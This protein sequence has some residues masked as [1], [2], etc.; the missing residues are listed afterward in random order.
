MIKRI[1]KEELLY[2]VND[3]GKIKLGTNLHRPNIG[4]TKYGAKIYWSIESL[5][6]A[7]ELAQDDGVDL[8]M[9]D[10]CLVS[11]E[12]SYYCKINGMRYKVTQKK[13]AMYGKIYHKIELI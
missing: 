10:D 6:M 5:L 7:E 11:W 4:F 12:Y 8:P 1:H 13:K 2:E 9:F 3:R